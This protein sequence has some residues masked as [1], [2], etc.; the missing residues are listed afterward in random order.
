MLIPIRE[1]LLISTGGP[2]PM[3]SPCDDDDGAA[4][5]LWCVCTVVLVRLRA[6]RHG[7]ALPQRQKLKFSAAVEFVA[8]L[9]A[10]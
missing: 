7:P 5:G 2:G 1:A 3:V 10:K 6:A 9:S 4:D 8:I